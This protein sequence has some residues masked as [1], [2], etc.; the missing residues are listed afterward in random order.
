M[1][2]DPLPKAFPIGMP[3]FFQI[4]L[5]ESRR[6]SYE[7]AGYQLAIHA[8]EFVMGDEDADIRLAEAIETDDAF[9]IVTWMQRELPQCLA[10]IPKRRLPTFA[11]GV[12]RA[13]LDEE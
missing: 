7:R 8:R 11:K 5:L 4:A 10:A 13:L 12:A 3:R 6:S 1:N 2:R 9:A